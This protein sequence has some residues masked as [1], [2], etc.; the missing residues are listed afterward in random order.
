MFR[1]EVWGI[2]I[3]FLAGCLGMWRALERGEVKEVAVHP[4]SV[5][6]VEAGREVVAA[7]VVEG[8]EASGRV[9]EKCGFERFAMAKER[10]LRDPKRQV[11]IIGCRAVL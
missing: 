3:E 10:D 4:A 7:L 9:L 5:D 11:E 6:G 8:N 1:R 2:A